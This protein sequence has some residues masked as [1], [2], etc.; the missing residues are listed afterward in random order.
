M[1][2]LR[3]LSIELLHSL[4]EIPLEFKLFSIR[5]CFGPK[6]DPIALD[7]INF[8]VL[9]R[10]TNFLVDDSDIFEDCPVMMMPYAKKIL[11]WI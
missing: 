8:V 7:S 4:F 2:R 11:H 5:V 3:A 1:K 10:N 6:M 9:L